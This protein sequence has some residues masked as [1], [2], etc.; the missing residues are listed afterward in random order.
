M[1]Q[2][3][4][5]NPI[6]QAASHENSTATR[7]IS[8][9]FLPA[10][11]LAAAL[12]FLP[13]GS[14]SSALNSL[15]IVFVS[16]VLEAIPFMLVGSL[17]GG[18]IEAFVSRERMAALLPRKGWLTVCLA[19]GAGVVFPVCECAV[20]PVVR[21]LIGKGLPLSAAVAY[22][23]G[24][25]IV[26]PIVA[27]STALA[28]AFDWRVVALRLGLGYG[29]AVAIGML[30]GRLFAGGGAV[31]DNGATFDSTVSSCGC[32]HH[33]MTQPLNGSATGTAQS[34]PLST[35]QAGNT[36]ACGCGCSH[37]VSDSWL[38]KA[39]AA[40]AHAMDDFL[41]VGHYLVI[42]AF[43]AALA[44]TYIDRSSF[45]SLAAVPVLSVVLMMA[46]AVLLNLCSEADAFIAAS[47]RGLM[48]LPA[49]MAFLLTGPMF[50]LKLLL[51]YQSVF[52]RRA[53]A[54]L[55]SLVLAA[56]LA[57]SLGLEMLNGM[58]Q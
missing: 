7:G 16:I 26:N 1:A 6:T 54:V 30:M 58:L 34:F 31:K 19:A 39:G 52:T 24:G 32:Q 35:E 4:K 27:A 22:L 41:A 20:V 53:I 48:P 36:E 12:F 57:T 45:L 18:L 10:L 33:P 23:L 15:A 17:V 25:P 29:I 51:M 11:F 21:R 40:F 56:V 37:P 38:D 55:A 47:F 13:S 44:Q 28:Y 9:D 50:D 42:G 5:L 8:I 3:R 49:Q 43:I 2:P 46:L 14:E